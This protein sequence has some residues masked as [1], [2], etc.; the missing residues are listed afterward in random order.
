[1]NLGMEQEME[2]KQ[3]LIEQIRL[4]MPMKLGP[5]E[6]QLLDKV[7][8]DSNT[9]DPEEGNPFYKILEALVIRRSSKDKTL[10]GQICKN[11]GIL[12]TDIKKI[13]VK[14][15]EIADLGINFGTKRIVAKI[16]LVDKIDRTL[17]ATVSIDRNSCDPA[18]KYSPSIQEAKTL[19]KIDPA[20]TWSLQRLLGSKKIEDEEGIKG[21]IAKEFIPGRMLMDYGFLG[22]MGVAPEAGNEYLAQ[23]CDSVGRA[24]KNC[25]E[26]TGAIPTDSNPLNFIVGVD[27]NNGLH[28]RWCDTEGL[29]SGSK[30]Q[31]RQIELIKQTVGP[32]AAAFEQGLNAESQPLTLSPLLQTAEPSGNTGF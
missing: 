28:T 1:M 13:I 7:S 21:V 9:G 15:F 20:R 29:I 32:Y 23:I 27:P 19:K 8:F 31:R 3:H 25:L 18:G 5:L 24:A 2:M 30:N 14:N 4:V 12:E 11:V 22:E 16:I 10:I 26:T 6:N 17:R